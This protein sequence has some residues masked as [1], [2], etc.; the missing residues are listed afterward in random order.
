MVFVYSVSE[1]HQR[2]INIVP[3]TES[4]VNMSRGTRN[5]LNS[6]LV[7]LYGTVRRALCLI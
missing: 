7:L 3:H 1:I 2:T 6:S 5:L 4:L